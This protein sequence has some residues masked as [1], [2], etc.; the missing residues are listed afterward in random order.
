MKYLI[1]LLLTLPTFAE[2]VGDY[3]NYYLKGRKTH[4]INPGR[5]DEITDQLYVESK[6]EVAFKK[7]DYLIGATQEKVFGAIMPTENIGLEAFISAFNGEGIEKYGATIGTN[8]AENYNFYIG[9]EDGKEIKFTPHF[10]LGLEVFKGALFLEYTGQI[11]SPEEYSYKAGWGKIYDNIFGDLTYEA[12][13]FKNRSLQVTIGGK[14]HI[15]ERLI[16]TAAISKELYFTKELKASTHLQW[17]P[18]NKLE[19]Y[20]INNFMAFG[21]PDPSYSDFEVNVGLAYYL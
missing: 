20:L 13:N 21:S 10:G 16:G 8:L 19:I 11:F 18:T 17:F 2:E 4:F 12:D 1:L 3:T 9:F 15:F 5:L 7:N 14:S 6:G